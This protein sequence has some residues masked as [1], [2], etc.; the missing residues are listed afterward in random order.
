MFLFFTLLIS[1]GCNE[2]DSPVELKV[3]TSE[4]NPIAAAEAVSNS[5]ETMEVESL[6]PPEIIVS[7][8][9]TTVPES[10]AELVSEPTAVVEPESTVADDT[11][12][13]DTFDGVTKIVRYL[14]EGQEFFS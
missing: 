6:T 7:S 14:Y 1:I 5:E 4:S 11:S 2:Q 12:S 9:T 3:Q 8:I 10:E 13:S